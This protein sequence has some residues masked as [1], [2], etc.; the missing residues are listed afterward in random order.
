M[1]ELEE[2]VKVTVQEIIAS[3]MRLAF[4]PMSYDCQRFRSTGNSSISATY[5]E[6][7]GD[8]A[9]IS[10]GGLQNTSDTLP[11]GDCLGWNALQFYAE[12]LPNSTACFE[13]EYILHLEGCPQEA[14]KALVPSDG[15]PAFVGGAGTFDRIVAIMSSKPMLEIVSMVGAATGRSDSARHL[16]SLLGIMTRLGGAGFR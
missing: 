7:T 16:S 11:E 14:S 3:E 5:E 13:L 8:I 2:S 6:V 4:R 1:T 15:S 9:Y 10:T 12:G